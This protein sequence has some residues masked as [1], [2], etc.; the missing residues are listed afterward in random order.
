M[1][2]A[3]G[4]QQLVK[5]LTD[6]HSIEEQ[7]LT[8]MRR[9][10]KLVDGR[11]AAAFELHLEETVEQERRVRERLEAHEA[12]PSKLKDA[13]GQAGGVGMVLFARSQP[14]TPGKLTAHAFSYEHMELAAYELLSRFAE[15][16]GDAETATMARDIATQE[17]AMAARLAECF[18]EAVAASLDGADEETAAQH[19]DAYLADAH[20]IEGQS[21]TLLKKGAGIAGAEELAK[22]FEAHLAESG[23]Q[24]RRLERRLQAR[25]SSPSAL[26]DA[27]LRVG[28]LNW[29]AFMAAQPDTPAKLAG[30]A[31]A[32]EHLEIG[33][34]ELLLRVA[35]RAGDAETAAVVRQTLEE[36]RAAAAAIADHWDAALD[37]A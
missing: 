2:A 35:E 19:L 12:S 21:L 6:V 31:Y 8:Q 34:Y 33:S 37:A 1:S 13:A 29:G 23:E 28:G 7:A 27:A 18:D 15:R 26:K 24:Q 20:A 5:Y 4:E 16:A 30:F 3:A 36:E 22:V 11:L 9:A 25:G 32:L 10:P 14:D 17:Q